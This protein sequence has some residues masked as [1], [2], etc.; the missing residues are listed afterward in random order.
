M[1]LKTSR[2]LSDAH[3]ELRRRWDW[4]RS[5]YNLRYPGDPLPDHDCTYRD[6]ETQRRDVASGASKV[7]YPNSTHNYATEAGGI[8]IAMS[9]ALDFHFDEGDGK[10]S[11]RGDWMNRVIE[12]S[13]EAGLFSGYLGWG[14]DKPHIALCESPSDWPKELPPLPSDEPENSKRVENV[15]RLVMHDVSGGAPAVVTGLPGEDAI[16]RVS[17]SHKK[18]DVRFDTDRREYAAS[19]LKELALAGFRPGDTLPTPYPMT[20]EQLEKHLEG[21]DMQ[22]HEPAEVAK[23]RGMA[24]RA[25][26]AEPYKTGEQEAIVQYVLLIGPSVIAVGSFLST[27]GIIQYTPAQITEFWNVFQDAASILTPPVLLI[28]ALIARKKVFSLA[29]VNEMLANL[30]AG[31]K[32]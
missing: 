28:T 1:E 4:I 5:E 17:F 25:E 13:Q 9:L 2:S 6:E 18:V 21:E 31:L 14:W 32:R 23:L 8:P 24:N 15:P 27:A 29:S 12:L 11:Y 26:E 7:H 10:T 22:Q 20:L 16:I 30:R 3:P 19:I